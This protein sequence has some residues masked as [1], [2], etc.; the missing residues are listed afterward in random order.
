MH[1]VLRIWWCS[2]MTHNARWNYQ[3]VPWSAQQPHGRP[4]FQVLRS[5]GLQNA[6]NT[7][8]AMAK[9]AG[10]TVLQV[11]LLVEE[12][13]G[14]GFQVNNLAVRR[15]WRLGMIWNSIREY[16]TQQNP[17]HDI[18][19]WR[20][21]LPKKTCSRTPNLSQP[22]LISATCLALFWASFFHTPSHAT[23]RSSYT[24][25]TMSYHLGL[26]HQPG[27]NWGWP[28]KIIKTSVV[29]GILKTT[30]IHKI[31]PPKKKNTI[32]RF[33]FD[34]HSVFSFAF[35]VAILMYSII[36]VHERVGHLYRNQWPKLV[37]SFFYLSLSLS[38]SLLSLPQ[39]FF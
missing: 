34:S 31:P 8:P 13:D 4:F 11:L 20:Y 29:W 3:D 5:P 27:H 2:K 38:L 23:F 16:W 22:L 21:K 9:Q 14:T 12:L 15:L 24:W 18:R 25:H 36:N 19:M 28:T 26:V 10:L 30:L 17:D 33:I 32:S 39:L 6:P 37:Q 35:L 1:I 7:W